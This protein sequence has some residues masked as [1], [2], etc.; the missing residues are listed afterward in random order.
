MPTP[1]TGW[2]T[3]EMEA[4]SLLNLALGAVLIGVAS[5][6]G[7]AGAAFW[8]ALTVGVLV[9]V[10]EIFDEWAEMHGLAAEIVGPEAVNVLAG[11]WL[12]VFPFFVPVSPLYAAITVA[13]GVAIAFAAGFNLVLAVRTSSPPR[14]G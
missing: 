8:S 13:I 3:L 2:R 7:P 12:V 6:V 4:L 1:E 10:L 9:V 5:L 14:P 11:L